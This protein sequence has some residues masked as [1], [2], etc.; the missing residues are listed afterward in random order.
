VATTGHNTVQPDISRQD[1]HFKTPYEVRLACRENRLNGV[2][3]HALPG[4]LCVNVIILDKDYADEF[5]AFCAANPKPCPVI[6][7]LEPGQVDCPKFAKDL[8][9]RTDLGSYDVVREGK[10]E[11][12][13][14]VNDL[15]T[16]RMV[17]FLVGSSTS[18]EGLLP[19]KGFKPRF[20]GTVQNTSVDC[21]PVGMFKGKMAVTVRAFDPDMTDKVWEFTSHL[22]LVHGAPVGKNNWEE[23]GIDKDVDWWGK[24]ISIPEGTDR[25]YWGCGVT[26]L[27]VAL[28][29]NLPFMISYT[30]KH[31]MITDVPTESLYVP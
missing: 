3:S 11:Q 7:R 29:A 9:I 6:A 15:F 1:T 23:L 18:F 16:D 20:L 31:A 19:M 8:D 14:D 28:D 2:A 24:R 22:P 17:T 27:Q 5:A 21:K 10:I 4:Y 13:K 25:L 12:V 26:P 30:P